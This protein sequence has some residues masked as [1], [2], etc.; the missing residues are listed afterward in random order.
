MRRNSSTLGC[1]AALFLFA[2]AALGEE[3]PYNF[4]LD[5]RNI[6]LG[7]T[8]RIHEGYGT[9]GDVV[10]E[11]SGSVGGYGNVNGVL[12]H[13]GDDIS[14]M[15]IELLTAGLNEP[16]YLDGYVEGIHLEAWTGDVT[17]IGWSTYRIDVA[18]SGDFF[19][20]YKASFGP[21]TDPIMVRVADFLEFEIPV[22]HFP[23]FDGYPLNGNVTMTQG[24]PFLNL[25]MELGDSAYLGDLVPD[26]DY[27][28]WGG[29][30]I[31]IAVPEPA[32]LAALAL[33]GLG[34]LQRRRRR[35]DWGKRAPIGRIRSDP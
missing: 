15:E 2:S 28:F 14:Q 35:D 33:G 22:Y 5:E 6:S 30:T 11:L 9:G 7:Y 16:F 19:H 29:L 18:P 17:V 24:Q 31:T 23:K 8:V 1:A 25:S 34:V 20:D 21:E 3:T 32:S 27:T 13:D 12:Y 4:P 10:F 26:L